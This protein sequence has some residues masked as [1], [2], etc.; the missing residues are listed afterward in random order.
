MKTWRDDFKSLLNAVQS[1]KR[2][3]EDMVNMDEENNNLLNSVIST[4]EVSDA[5][6]AMK[7]NK[8]FGVGG[9]P[10]EHHRKFSVWG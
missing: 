4:Q 6:K 3:I 1:V 8:A 7:R 2:N 5:M 10:A 9:L